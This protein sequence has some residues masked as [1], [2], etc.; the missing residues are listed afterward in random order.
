MKADGSE[1]RPL[2]KYGATGPR[3]GHARF[4]PDGK[5]ILYVRAATQ[6]WQSPPAAYLR[7][8]PGHR[9]GRSRV[10]GAGHLHTANA[11]ASIVGGAKWT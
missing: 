9:S 4:T 6:D 5:A 8:R 1:L 11:A 2:T 10:D 3:A 7:D